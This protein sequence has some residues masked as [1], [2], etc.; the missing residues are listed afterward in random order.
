MSSNNWSP[1]RLSAT[2][3]SVGT[4]PAAGSPPGATTPGM[5]ARG[6][7]KGPIKGARI[8]GGLTA[9]ARISCSMSDMP[10]ERAPVSPSRMRAS[11]SDMPCERAPVS[12][13]RMRA[14]MSDMPRGAVVNC[15][16]LGT[17]KS[18][19][20]PAE[21]MSLAVPLWN[22]SGYVSETL[23]VFM[24]SPTAETPDPI[25]DLIAASPAS[26][27]KAPVTTDEVIALVTASGAFGNALFTWSETTGVSAAETVE[28]I[29][30][31]RFDPGFAKVV[32]PALAAWLT[33]DPTGADGNKLPIPTPNACPPT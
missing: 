16:P 18:E 12:P 9:S 25:N 1:K 10:C 7:I 28:I 17:A 8:V 30:S 33:I 26:P 20:K 6:P 5:G 19:G 22:S 21:T 2:V 27:P 23:G 13:S 31:F 4:G 29:A 24:I 15:V 14:S 32:K 3:N 11:I